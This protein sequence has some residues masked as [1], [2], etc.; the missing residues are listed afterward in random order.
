MLSFG[1]MYAQPG[2][3]CTYGDS[4]IYCAVN[5]YWEPQ[6]YTLPKLPP[7]MSWTRL[8]YSAEAMI[9]KVPVTGDKI[10][11]EARSSMVLIGFTGPGYRIGSLPKYCRPPKRYLSEI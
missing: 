10:T 11:L 2:F 3:N 1:F 4:F 7:G 5:E 8:L 9:R 6:T